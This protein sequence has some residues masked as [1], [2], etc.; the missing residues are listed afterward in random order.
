MQVAQVQEVTVAK[1]AAQAQREGHQEQAKAVAQAADPAL[2]Q[3]AAH[4]QGQNANVRVLHLWHLLVPV[5]TLRVRLP[6]KL[7][8]R[9]KG[10]QSTRSKP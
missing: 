10:G 2:S 8:Q 4:R 9:L 7:L 6:A 3:A 5:E 1:E